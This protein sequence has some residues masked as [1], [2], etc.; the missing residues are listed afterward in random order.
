MTDQVCFANKH[1]GMER[2]PFHIMETKVPGNPFLRY[3][4][5][6]STRMKICDSCALQLE[7]I[8][9]AFIHGFIFLNSDIWVKIFPLEL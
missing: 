9:A 7:K 8:C 2:R 6:I 1:V 5:T 3:V 4:P